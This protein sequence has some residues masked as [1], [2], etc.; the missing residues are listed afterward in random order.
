[1][2]PIFDSGAAA[3]HSQDAALLAA[4]AALRASAQ[5]V[6]HEVAL[7]FE[8]LST[9]TA[10]LSDHARD[11]ADR[12]RA[13][14]ESTER[15]FRA[16]EIEYSELALARRDEVQARITLLEA[17]LAVSSAQVDMDA[18]TGAITIPGN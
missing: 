1:M 13:L 8:T 10:Y 9:S 12:R 16:G 11:L 17:R 14:R 4:A 7:A 2:L 18:A 15:L 5:S 3:E 6:A